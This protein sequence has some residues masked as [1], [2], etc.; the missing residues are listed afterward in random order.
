MYFK[1][2]ATPSEDGGGVLRFVSKD[3]P[4]DSPAHYALGP[5]MSQRRT[6]HLSLSEALGWYARAAEKGYPEAL[7]KIGLM[8]FTG[9]GVP[10]SEEKAREWFERA[11]ELEMDAE[12]EALALARARVAALLEGL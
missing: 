8:H 1:G 2:D 6:M 7:Y 4:M 11:E 3:E 5:L 9:A 10:V 12:L